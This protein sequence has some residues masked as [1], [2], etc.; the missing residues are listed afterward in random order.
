MLTIRVQV[1]TNDYDENDSYSP[2]LLNL[3]TYHEWQAVTDTPYW[4]VEGDAYTGT[5][6][7][8]QVNY[9]DQ[10]MLRCLINKMV[11]CL[12][13]RLIR[14]HI[15]DKLVEF[16]GGVMKMDPAWLKEME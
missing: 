8:S 14:I 3:A 15:N 12:G 16:V 13:D 10:L 6:Y 5:T 9:R 7:E 11:E 2:Y 1:D 4:Y